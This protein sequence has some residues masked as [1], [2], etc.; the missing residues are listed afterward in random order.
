MVQSGE[1][2]SPN[3]PNTILANYLM[4]QFKGNVK[5]IKRKWVDTPP[6]L[7]DVFILGKEGKLFSQVRIWV[8]DA[9]L[10]YPQIGYFISIKNA[11]SSAFAKCSF[12]DFEELW[13]WLGDV[14]RK[15]KEIQP[16]LDTKLNTV[17]QT[18]KFQE[19]LEEMSGLY[20]NQ[21][22]GDNNLDAPD[23][24]DMED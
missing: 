11:N 10:R 6:V 2:L 16:N 21:D 7:Q 9:T 23:P 1:N 24:D 14:I 3:N 18:I 4:G 13:V 5:P 19:Q 12:S 15:I 22:T 8:H 20:N 17:N